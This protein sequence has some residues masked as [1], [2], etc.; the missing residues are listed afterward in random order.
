MSRSALHVTL[1]LVAL[2]LFLTSCDRRLPAQEDSGASLASLLEELRGE[3]DAGRL[4]HAVTSLERELREGRL[5]IPGVR[6]AEELTVALTGL[7]ERG[8]ALDSLTRSSVVGLLASHPHAAARDALLAVAREEATHDFGARWR[9]LEALVALREREVLPLLIEGL[10]RDAGRIDTHVARLIAEL[11]D[12]AGIEPLEELLEGGDLGETHREGLRRA[13]RDLRLLI[14]DRIVNPFDLGDHAL[15]GLQ[16]NGFVILPEAKNEM[17]ELYEQ[18]YPFVTTDVAF[19]TFMIVMR[20]AFLELEGLLLKPRLLEL[21]RN[22]VRECLRQGK[23]LREPRLATLACANAA[24]FAVPAVL[25]G[26]GDPAAL[27]L[28]A[29]L[30]EAVRAET[31]LIRAHAGVAPSH[32]FGYREDFTKYKPRGRHSSVPELTGYFQGMVYYGRMMLRIESRE[33][34]RQA[35]LLAA[36]FARRPGFLDEWKEIDGLLGQLF[37]ERDDL[38]LPDYRDAADEVTASLRGKSAADRLISIAQRER[39]FDRFVEKLEERAAPR[40][41]TACLPWPESMRWKTKTRGLRIFGQRYA[42]PIHVFQQYTEHAEWPPSGLHVAAELLGSRR[43]REILE[44]A[45]IPNGPGLYTVPPPAPDPLGNLSDGFLHCAQALFETPEGAPPFL[46]TAAWEEKQINT[47][48]GSWAE[49]RHSIQLYSKDA[50]FTV[51]ASAM[52]DRFHGY[53]EPFP[54]FYTRLDALLWRMVEA[55]EGCGLF[56]RIERDRKA[57][58]KKMDAAEKKRGDRDSGGWDPER[59]RRDLERREA[60]IRVDRAAVEELSTMLRRFASIAAKELRGEAQSIDDG[61]FLKGLERRLV[62]LSF[63][64]SNTSTAQQSMAVISDVATEYRSGECLEVGVGRPRAIYV[65]VPDAGRT[66]VC[67]GAVYTYYE[68]LRPIDERLDDREWKELSLDVEESELRP[69][70]ESRPELDGTPPHRS[71]GRPA[72]PRQE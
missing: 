12:P 57:V 5:S 14:D 2:P 62:R 42:R 16:R 8:E 13:L 48:L 23:G 35:L 66:F 45:A 69:W 1:L 70:I 43:A 27:G 52:V 4:R 71:G 46:K 51:G 41:N 40:I 60:E 15:R 63:N 37:G 25:L 33:E 39:L 28:P 21:S 11:G 6:E 61:V 10:A 58:L 9:A 31:R 17:F 56:D 26:G 30:R 38:C 72:D 65:A 19:H 59:D 32:L 20:A 67:K 54:D 53:V 44:E 22:L 3:E 55:F 7:L 29:E 68:F 64:R 34:S 50:N 24:F 49:V 18:A 47:A 36:L